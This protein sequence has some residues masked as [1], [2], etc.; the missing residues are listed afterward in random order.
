MTAAHGALTEGPVGR[1]LLN[2]AAPMLLGIASILL[3]NIVD[4]FFVGQLGAWE[5]A[6]MSFTFPVTFVVLSIAMGMGIGATAVISAAIGHGDEAKVRR[7]TTDAIILANVIV[8]LVV[9]LGLLLQTPTFR[10]L[11]A[12]VEM[13]ALIL[14]YMTPWWIG[15]GFLVIPMVGN[16]AIRATGDMK[17]PAYI[18]MTAGGLN[19]LLDPLLI[20]GL[21]PLPRLELQGAAIATVLSWMTTFVAASWVLIRRER[22]IDFRWPT[23]EVLFDSWSSILKVGLPAAGTNLLVPLGFALLTRIVAEHGTE[24]VAAWGVAN[25][26]E[27]LSMVGIAALSTAMTPF[28]GQNMGAGRCDRLREAVRFSIKASF[29][30]GLGVAL[31]LSALARPIAGAFNSE[32]SVIGLVVLFLYTVPI[33]YT[34]FGVV[35]LMGSFFNG[36]QRPMKAALL[37]VLRLFVFGVPL[38]F[39]G[40]QIDGMRG[41]FLGISLG[42][43]L[44]GGAAIYMVR[45]LIDRHEEDLAR[46]GIHAEAPLPST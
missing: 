23:T 10:L 45:S 3:F 19:L 21:G 27:G 39:L 29:S 36:S 30:W 25:R 16:S 34:F 18:M 13:T 22:M 2:K 43:L 15:V 14:E 4:T 20:F 9:V 7:L 11:G 32:P 46:G 40:A 6:A 17:T 28:V 37:T 12:D 44:I 33:S 1:T 24:A 8:V 42:N 5:L 26:L 38:A 41:M 35:Q 31:V